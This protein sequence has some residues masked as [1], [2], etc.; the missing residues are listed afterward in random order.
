MFLIFCWLCFILMI[1]KLLVISAVIRYLTSTLGNIKLI[2]TFRKSEVTSPEDLKDKEVS[3][4]SSVQN[5]S[6]LCRY[7]FVRFCKMESIKNVHLK[8]DIFFISC[9]GHTLPYL[10]PRQHTLCCILCVHWSSSLSPPPHNLTI[11][12]LLIMI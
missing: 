5:S 3:L 6:L 9:P 1:I 2:S 7:F 11:C 10:L 12:I 8:F 4:V